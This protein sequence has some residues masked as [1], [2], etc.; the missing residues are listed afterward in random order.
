MT[1]ATRTEMRR[2]GQ[3]WPDEDAALRSK[4]FLAGGYDLKTGCPCGEVHLTK[5][6][7]AEKAAKAAKPKAPASAPE[8]FSGAVCQLID[9][10]DGDDDGAELVRLCQRCGSTRNL[11]RHHRR[12]KGEGGASGPHAHCACNGVT[13]CLACHDEIHNRAGRQQM[14]AEGWIVSQAI[15]RP[16]TRG[17]M[18]FA[19]A[20]GGATHWP[21]CEGHWLETG[22]EAAA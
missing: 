15:L 5:A 9:L 18:R 16:G 20:E 12:L 3:R 8:S 1:L 11:H 14:E 22:P 17:V 13:V 2:C 10:R 21:S 7:T 19:A 4:K 6:A